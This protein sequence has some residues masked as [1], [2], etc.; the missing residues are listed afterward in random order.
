MAS[1]MKSGVGRREEGALRGPPAA[2]R[3]KYRLRDSAKPVLIPG[4]GTLD[5]QRLAGGSKQA[6]AGVH[7]GQG[8]VGPGHAGSPHPR[9]TPTSGPG[10][11][12]YLLGGRRGHGDPHA[13]PRQDREDLVLKADS[14]RVTL[15]L[16]WGQGHPPR[17]PGPSPPWSPGWRDPHGPGLTSQRA[18]ADRVPAQMP[19]RST[20]RRST[21]P[22]VLR[23]NRP[24]YQGGSLLH[25][26]T[27]A[28]S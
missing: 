6:Q 15:G 5:S 28:R 24:R 18:Q 19:P 7:A 23:S 21:R 10:Q 25:D 17:T 20:A 22:P 9:P 12:L 13:R 11:R 27:A 16:S 3:R 14:R 1:A 4:G 8:L 2:A 26:P